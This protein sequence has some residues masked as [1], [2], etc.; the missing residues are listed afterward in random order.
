MSFFILS[1]LLFFLV[2]KKKQYFG[3]GFFFLLL[4]L[5]LFKLRFDL[6]SSFF[7]IFFYLRFDLLFL[8]ALRQIFNIFPTKKGGTLKI[9][10]QTF[11]SLVLCCYCKNNTVLNYNVIWLM[12]GERN[13]TITTFY[14]LS[15]HFC[16]N[17][18]VERLQCFFWLQN[19]MWFI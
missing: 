15:F 2:T 13:T 7:F 5:L 12:T 19:R 4:L 14:K 10:Q 17:S 16:T 18:A 11:F 3:R 8:A 9:S 6:S 1:S